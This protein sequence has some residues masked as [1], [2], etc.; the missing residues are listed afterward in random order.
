[1]NPLEEFRRWF[2]EAVK[3]G[4]S[5]PEAMA[6]ATSVDGRSSVRFVLMRGID[7]NGI[8][9]YTNRQSRKARD[10]ATNPQASMAIFWEPL[11]KQV[12]ME[13]HVEAL[14]PEEDDA[15]FNSRPRGHQLGAWASPQ[16]E[17]IS[18]EELLQ[19]L[20]VVEKRFEGKPVERPPHW[21][22]YRLLVDHVEFWT[23]QPNR[24]H[25]RE[26]F[27]LSKGTWSS[28]IVAP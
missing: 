4:L 10:L 24:L 17:P 15:Y 20:A 11:Y 14:T 12:S 1:M 27:T 16:S 13:G 25:H 2:D 28:R 8:R 9:F 3:K 7:A 22:G 5:Q 23:G 18:R 6:L 19:R 21:G 26:I